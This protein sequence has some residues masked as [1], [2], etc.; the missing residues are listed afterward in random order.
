MSILEKFSSQLVRDGNTIPS[1]L[2][3]AITGVGHR[4]ESST[5][6]LPQASSSASL[7]QLEQCNKNSS[8]WT[9]QALVNDENSASSCYPSR[10]RGQSGQLSL[11]QDWIL[12]VLELFSFCYWQVI[13]LGYYMLTFEHLS[14]VVTMASYPVFAADLHSVYS[15]FPWKRVKIFLLFFQ[16]D[17]TSNTFKVYVLECVYKHF[18]EFIHTFPENWA[19]CSQKYAKDCSYSIP[20][21]L[22]RSAVKPCI[23]CLLRGA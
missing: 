23:R 4:E 9:A 11:A 8:M 15:F 16:S 1:C 3:S 22:S 12:C 5:Q 18:L 19:W 10:G 13:T 17:M 14:M 7:A 21:V 2:V 20:S 6:L